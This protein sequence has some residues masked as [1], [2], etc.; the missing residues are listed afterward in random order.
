[1]RKSTIELVKD[2]F[3]FAVILVRT[4]NEEILENKELFAEV[5]NQSTDM[6]GNRSFLPPNKKTEFFTA[7]SLRLLL[8]VRLPRK[9]KQEIIDEFGDAFDELNMALAGVST[10]FK[11]NSVSVASPSPAY[12]ID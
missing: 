8:T 6:E 7:D 12:H 2:I 9:V 1:M 3:A 11:E 4:G 10:M 5:L